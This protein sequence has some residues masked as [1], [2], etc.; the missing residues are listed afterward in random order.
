MENMSDGRY[1]ELPAKYCCGT[2]DL[3]LSGPAQG[4]PVACGS[5]ISC[6]KDFPRPGDVE[7]TLM[8]R[9]TVRQVLSAEEV[10]A[11]DKAGFGLLGSQ[12]EGGLGD[13]CKG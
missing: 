3:A 2:G 9:G 8:K 11:G 13:R 1:R 6:R 4:R 7:G 12:R 10:T 5:L